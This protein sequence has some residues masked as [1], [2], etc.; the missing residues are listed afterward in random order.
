[1]NTVIVGVSFLTESAFYFSSPIEESL[2][3]C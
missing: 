1:M 2:D 3:I